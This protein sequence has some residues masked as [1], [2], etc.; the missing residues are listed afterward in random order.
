[1]HDLLH[2][3]ITWSI[4]AEAC[5]QFPPVPCVCFLLVADMM[6]LLQHSNCFSSDLTCMYKEAIQMR[7]YT[8]RPLGLSNECREKHS[9]FVL[10]NFVVD[11]WSIYGEDV[12]L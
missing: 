1:M 3:S 6:L 5:S 7:S 2:S 12:L 11:R 10:R 9:D 8:D 4:L